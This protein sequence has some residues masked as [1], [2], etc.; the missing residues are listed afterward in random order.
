[1]SG[2]LESDLQA[3]YRGQLQ[4]YMERAWWLGVIPAAMLAMLA[5][6]TAGEV[7]FNTSTWTFYLCQV[8]LT[9]FC[10]TVLL[11]C[12]RGTIKRLHDHASTLV[13]SFGHKSLS[14]A[15]RWWDYC[16]RSVL[17]FILHEFAFLIGFIFYVLVLAMNGRSTWLVA[18]SVG[19]AA[20]V[21]IELLAYRVALNRWGRR[22]LV[23]WLATLL[24]CAAV[25]ALGRFW[26]DS[27]V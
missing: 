24:G 9:L 18:A 12:H 8:L 19:I 6:Y 27:S 26:V 13:D 4:A 2:S 10:C 25:M 5:E 22:A 11:R 16:P 1:M 23:L 15:V 20:A 3:R 21:P 14:K 17:L 7:G